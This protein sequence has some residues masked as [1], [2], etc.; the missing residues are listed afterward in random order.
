MVPRRG[1]T[2]LRIIS[3]LQFPTAA[4]RTVVYRA[5][6]T[7]VSHSDVCLRPGERKPGEVVC[8][9]ASSLTGS[10]LGRLANPPAGISRMAGRGAIAW[11]KTAALSQ[12]WRPEY[13]PLW[14]T[15][16]ALE[17]L[18]GDFVIRAPP[19]PH[20][21]RYIT[22]LPSPTGRLPFCLGLD[23]PHHRCSRF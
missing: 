15:T 22:R 16:P 17:E 23:R 1:V 3:K 21:R 6:W 18:S 5:F 12:I 2:L 20:P 19:P 8:A 13:V 7:G 14:I 9:N 11:N 10:T 4:K